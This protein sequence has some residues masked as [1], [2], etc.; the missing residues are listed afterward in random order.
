[1]TN[2]NLTIPQDST[3]SKT[4]NLT[5]DDGSGV[6]NL[7]GYTANAIFKQYYDT[8][9]TVGTF[10]T[11]INATAGSI[12][13]SLSPNNTINVESGRYVYDIKLTDGSGN[14]MRPI[15]G[16]LTISPCVTL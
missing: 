16:A 3:F 2:I 4:F 8:A 9:N 10:V 7:S 1:M 11:A 13:L 12:T 15:Q 5:N 14:I 6:F